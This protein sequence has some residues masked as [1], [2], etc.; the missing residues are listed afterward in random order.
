MNFNRYEV[1][2]NGGI[3]HVYKFPNGRGASVIQTDFSYGGRSGLWEV[4]VLDRDGNLDYSTPVTSDVIGWLSE[5]D[6]LGVLE[7]IAALN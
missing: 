1:Q 3:G 4:A 7:Q 5:D 2:F 6:V